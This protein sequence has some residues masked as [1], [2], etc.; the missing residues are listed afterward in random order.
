MEARADV[1][2]SHSA[3]GVK[4]GLDAQVHEVFDAAAMGYGDVLGL[5]SSVSEAVNTS[6]GAT[7]WNASSSAPGPSVLANQSLAWHWWIEGLPSSSASAVPFSFV[8]NVGQHDLLA[9]QPAGASTTPYRS[10]EGVR[11]HL[12]HAWPCLHPQVGKP[13]GRV[14]RRSSR[15]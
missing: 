2:C 5:A 4:A 3:T 1:A 9:S 8:M 13:R 15:N 11:P 10:P 7:L 12:Q 6:D 14:A